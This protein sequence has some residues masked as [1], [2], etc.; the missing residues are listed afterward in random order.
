MKWCTLIFAVVIVS[1]LLKI[2]Y[3][4]AESLS[5]SNPDIKGIWQGTLKVPSGQLRIVFKI[6]ED[7]QGNLKALIE[8]PDQTP[9]NFQADTIMFSRGNLK[10]V[11]NLIDILYQGTYNSDS[12]L[13]TGSLTQMGQSIPLVLKKIEKVEEALLITSEKEAS[14]IK[15]VQSFGDRLDVLVKS[16]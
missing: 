8:S 11:C 4:Q 7:A 14:A 1:L 16:L 9:Q 2:P 3:S 10:I 5:G 13:F 12:T 15:D 6:S